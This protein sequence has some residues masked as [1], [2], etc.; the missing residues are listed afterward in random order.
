MEVKKVAEYNY[1]F[2]AMILL[3]VS[4][5]NGIGLQTKRL[6]N[7]N[8][9][10]ITSDLG[11]KDLSYSSGALYYGILE[12]QIINVHWNDSIALVERKAKLSD[13]T[14]SYYILQESQ[15]PIG[16][17][18]IINGPYNINIFHNE[19]RRRGYDLSK[20]HSFYPFSRRTVFIETMKYSIFPVLVFLFIFFVIIRRIKRC[21]K[22]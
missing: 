11:Q 12:S 20:M 21:R 14:S 4:L 9:Y 10:I 8:L 18:Y 2:I 22:I 5:A 17:P 1:E 7:T 6:C 16:G 19:C 13:S 15:L 3:L